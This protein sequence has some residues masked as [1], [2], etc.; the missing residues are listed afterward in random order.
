MIAKAGPSLIRPGLG[1]SSG[2]PQV[3]HSHSTKNIPWPYVC[4]VRCKASLLQRAVFASTKNRCL[5]GLGWVD[6]RT[7]G[8]FTPSRAGS[9]GVD[10]QYGACHP[11]CFIT[12]QKSHSRSYIPPSSFSLQQATVLSRRSCLVAHATGVHHWRVDHA[13]TYAIHTNALWSMMNC[14]RASHVLSFTISVTLADS[15]MRRLTTI[16]PLL[17]G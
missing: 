2:L 3:G 16:A 13:G 7:L 9:T 1:I 17:V 8:Y 15:S 12:G 11:P 5:F 4:R 6:A 10:R 14:H